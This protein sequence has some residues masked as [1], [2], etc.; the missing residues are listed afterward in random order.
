M[1]A[2]EVKAVLESI[3][4]RPTKRLGQNFLLDDSVV[5]R[6]VG[7]A[8]LN[9]KD[10]VLEIGPGLGNLTEEILKSGAKVVGVEQDP[11]FCKFLER[12]FG[13]RV[14][15][16]QADA[17]KAFLPGFNKVVSN[18]PYQISSPIT[19]KLLDIGFDVAVLM[20]QREFAERMIAKPGTEDYG[21]LSVGVYY[22][23]DCEIMLN[24]P[25]H[26]FWPQP[27]VDSCVVRLVPKPPPFKV[28]DREAFFDVTRA[29]FS[30]RRKKISNSLKVDPATASL[31]TSDIQPSLDKLPYASKRAE[32]LSPEMIGELS[33]A[34]LDLSASSRGN[35][36]R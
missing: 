18:L 17:V 10:T 22:R 3:G 15:I 13:E 26:A 2:E 16:V 19:F 25:R 36:A 9:S 29:I 7:F 8:A 4:K 20:L 5:S 12:R 32:E 1:R 23:A 33:D 24:V 30:H 28:K 6:S 35:S 27:K 14:R 31:V 21:R 34:L 11:A